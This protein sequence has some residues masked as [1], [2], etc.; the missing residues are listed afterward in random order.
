MNVFLLFKETSD[1][2][3]TSDLVG[4]FSQRQL[5]ERYREYALKSVRCFITEVTIDDKQVP[6]SF[7][8]DYATQKSLALRLA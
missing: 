4:A 8:R 1:Q 3:G 5:A 6:D 7:A 2:Y